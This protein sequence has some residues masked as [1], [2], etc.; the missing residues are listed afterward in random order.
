MNFK[1]NKTSAV[2]SLTSKKNVADFQWKLI[3]FVF[4]PLNIIALCLAFYYFSLINHGEFVISV[5]ESSQKFQSVDTKKLTKIV[6]TFEQ[7]NT[8]FKNWT[9]DKT[10]VVDPSL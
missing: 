4:I 10:S 2:S 1:F 6:N 3:L 7:R 8:N 5:Q 9:P